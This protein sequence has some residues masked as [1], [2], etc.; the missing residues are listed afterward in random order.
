[1]TRDPYWSSLGV[2]VALAFSTSAKIRDATPNHG[3]RERAAEP[4]TAPS[5]EQPDETWSRQ[6]RRAWERKNGGPR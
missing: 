4:T 3:N 5:N 2:A 1:M 6:R